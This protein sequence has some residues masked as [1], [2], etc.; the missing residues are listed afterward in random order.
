MYTVFG[1]TFDSDIFADGEVNEGSRESRR[2]LD[3]RFHRV[4]CVDRELIY[5][6]LRGSAVAKRG[7]ISR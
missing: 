7:G 5:M 4:T 2:R 6:L 3:V 1:V